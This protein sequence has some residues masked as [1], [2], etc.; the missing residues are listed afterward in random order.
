MLL[1][2]QTSTGIIKPTIERPEHGLLKE[3]ALTVTEYESRGFLMKQKAFLKLYLYRCIDQN[4]DYGLHYLKELETE[5]Q[6]L[7]YRPTH[8]QMYKALHEMTLE[9][10]VN[11]EKKIKG[12]KG[13][14]FQEII[15]YTLTASGKKEYELYKK[16]M[17]VE[18]ERNRDLLNKALRDN[19]GPVK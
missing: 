8:S 18:L 1:H 19:Y 3:G 17:K 5:F 4:K 11:R 12:E 6:M 9:G 10:H 15:L 7:G 13:V 2:Q 16:Q 14:D